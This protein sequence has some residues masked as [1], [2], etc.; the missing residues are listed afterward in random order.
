MVPGAAALGPQGMASETGPSLLLALALLPW[1]QDAPQL[2][3]VHTCSQQT[4]FLVLGP[5]KG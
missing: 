3:R 2:S 4:V 5:V 1:W